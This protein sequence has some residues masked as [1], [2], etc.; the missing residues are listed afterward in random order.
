MKP[1]QERTHHWFE[2]IFYTLI[3]IKKWYVVNFFFISLLGERMV[4]RQTLFTL[5]TGQKDPQAPLM[6]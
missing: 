6:K 2:P 1:S 3:K 4:T 5:W